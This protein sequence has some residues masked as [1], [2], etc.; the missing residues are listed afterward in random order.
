MPRH[1]C[2]HCAA[3]LATGHRRDQHLHSIHIAWN[4]TTTTTTD[5]RRA[6]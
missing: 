6:A 3:L 4:T 5:P 1:A 2:A